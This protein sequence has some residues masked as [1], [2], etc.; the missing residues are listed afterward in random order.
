MNEYQIGVAA[1][2]ILYTVLGVAMYVFVKKS[3]KRF[4][5]AGKRLPFIVAGT[6]LY[7]QALDSNSTVGSASNAYQSRLLDRLRL[8]ARPGPVP[9]RHRACGSPSRSTR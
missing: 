9:H 6:M 4:I 5:I 1:L 2:L 3:G 8:P 7:A